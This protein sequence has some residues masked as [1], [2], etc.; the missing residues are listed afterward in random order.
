MRQDCQKADSAV[1]NSVQIQ[2]ASH[3]AGVGCGSRATL[4]PGPRFRTLSRY[5]GILTRVWEFFRLE[6]NTGERIGNSEPAALSPYRKE[7]VVWVQYWK[8]SCLVCKL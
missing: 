5:L 7:F 8:A 3:V 1:N 2:L 4:G 6:R